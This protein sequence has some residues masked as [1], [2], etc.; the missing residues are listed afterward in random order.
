M[1]S[2]LKSTLT[3]ICCG[4]VLWI[5]AAIVALAT[6]ASSTTLWICMCGAA[7]GVVGA[8]YSYRRNRRGEL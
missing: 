8:I 7:L 4:T 5:A 6:S 1:A 2:Q 3:V